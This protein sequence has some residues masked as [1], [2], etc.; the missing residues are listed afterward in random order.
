MDLMLFESNWRNDIVEFKRIAQQ[1]KRVLERRLPITLD[2]VLHLAS[3]VGHIELVATIVKLCPDLVAAVN[4]NQETPLHA[5]C[6][7]GNFQWLRSETKKNQSAFSLACEEGHLDIVK[8]MLNLSCLM[9]HEEDAVYAIPLHVAISNGHNEV[10][11]I[12]HLLHQQDQAGNTIL[13]LAVSTG[14][15]QLVEFILNAKVD[16]GCQNNKGQTALDM[17][18]QIGSRTDKTLLKEMLKTIGLNMS[19]ELPSD[20]LELEK[21]FSRSLE[22]PMTDTEKANPEEI[23]TVE[24]PK[25][26]LEEKITSLLQFRSKH[27]SRGK[28]NPITSLLNQ[29]DNPSHPEW[30]MERMDF[31]TNL[32]KHKHLSKSLG[33]SPALTAE[34]TSTNGLHKLQSKEKVDTVVVV[35]TQVD[36]H[37]MKRKKK[38]GKKTKCCLKKQKVGRRFATNLNGELSHFLS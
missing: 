19:I 31:P 3:R 16:V 38:G 22:L 36:P 17:I 18:E 14:N 11:D 7:L 6:R 37:S 2:S 12:S 29:E 35:P 24:D 13:H 21:Y 34:V 28:R 20:K 1:D 26:V 32:L 25:A 23:Q 33:R 10:S 4:E 8:L 9:E 15:L 5:A 30:L 27:K